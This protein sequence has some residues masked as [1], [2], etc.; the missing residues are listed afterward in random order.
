[1]KHLYT[2]AL[3]LSASALN[4]YAA[5][6][7][8]ATQWTTGIGSENDPYIIQTEEHLAYLQKTVADGD[9]YEGKFFRLAG[10]LDLS[11]LS[12]KTIGFYDVYSIDG[13]DYDESKPFLGVFDGAYNTID[14]VKIEIA[15]PANSM[16]GGVGLFALGKSSTVIKNL[17][18]GEKV[19]V[20]NNGFMTGGIMG[21]CDGA[22]IENCS[23]AGSIKGGEGETGGIAGRCENNAV[24]KG[25]INYGNVIGNTTTAGIVGSSANTKIIDCLHTGL[26]DGDQGY[27]VA[28]I[29]GWAENSEITTS[30]SLGIVLGIDGF[31]FMPGKSPVCADLD[32]S[33]AK[34][35]FYVKALTG[36]DPIAAQNGVKSVS[37]EVMKSSETLK[38]LNGGEEEGAWVAGANGDYPTLAWTLKATTGI[39]PIISATAADVKVDG[40]VIIINAQEADY[41]IADLCGRVIA[42][43][44]V[45]GEATFTPTVGGLYIVAVRT[46]EGTTVIKLQL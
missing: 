8:S 37:E 32:N 7:G 14:N 34:D 11:G 20:T 10:N 43:G 41:T 12:M 22:T 2:C 16:I 6:D 39:K 25:C 23:F 29:I 46:A 28:G 27:L 17:K 3:L 24:V 31:S 36:C 21:V 19:E 44:S 33:T 18:L 30:V 9:S 35:C 4:M 1:M 26:V 38:T 5:W 45:N 42:S 40:N 15:D 13:K